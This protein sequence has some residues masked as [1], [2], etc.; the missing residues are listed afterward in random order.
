[1]PCGEP[2]GAVTDHRQIDEGLMVTGIALVVADQT[3]AFDQPAEG[4]LF[5]PAPRQQDKTAGGI[6]AFND[7]QGQ[8]A[9]V[10]KEHSHPLHTSLQLAL[11]AAVGEDQAQAQE[12]MA[13]H[14]EENFGPVAV[15]H[16]GR[17]DHQTGQIAPGVGQQ[18]ALASFDLFAGIVAAA[19]GGCGVGTFDA[20]A[21]DDR[22]AGYGVFLPPRVSA[23]AGRC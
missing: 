4:A 7:L 23:R 6:A 13:K 16:T 11:I 1:M 14:T 21:V 5:D 19:P 9:G 15:L 2:A 20:L 12:Q 3:A 22:G 8:P 17:G 10:P 18:V